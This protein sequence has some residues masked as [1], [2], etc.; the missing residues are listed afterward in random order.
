MSRLTLWF[1]DQDTFETIDESE[2]AEVINLTDEGLA[3]AVSGTTLK[4]FTREEA[5]KFIVGR[6]P[7]E[8]LVSYFLE[9]HPGF[10]DEEPVKMV[11]KQVTLEVTYPEGEN[12]PDKWDWRGIT[13][14]DVRVRVVP[15]KESQDAG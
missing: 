12:P 7:I 1:S 10:F 5:E 14:S 15:E 13:G 4:K 2:G 11:T 9:G 6:V 3:A 8:T